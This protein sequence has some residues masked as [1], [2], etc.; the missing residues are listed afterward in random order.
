MS[1]DDAV[2]AW[3]QSCVRGGK[4]SRNTI[5]VGIVILDRLRQRVPLTEADILSK[6]GEISGSRAG[7]RKILTKYGIAEKFL[8]EVTTR[9][10]HQDGQRLLASLNWGKW[11]DRR[12]DVDLGNW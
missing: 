11:I 10:A 12:S 2:D 3:V 7:L 1:L 8:K 9:Q 5:A 6:G 4:I